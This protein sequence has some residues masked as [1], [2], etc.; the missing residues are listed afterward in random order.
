MMTYA[1]ATLL[2]V[3]NLAAWTAT[4]F[5]LPGNWFI[6]LMAAGYAYLMRDAVPQ[7]T[8]HVVIATLALAVI[9]E[10][11][12]LLAGVLGVKKLG[13]SRRGMIY[14]VIGTIAGSIVGA[15]VGVPIPVVGPIVGALGCG[16][17]GAF[18]GAYLGEVTAGRH[19]DDRMAIGKAALI[20][21]LL[22]TGGKLGVGLL[23]VILV[24]IDSFF[25]RAV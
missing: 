25:D 6:V 1:A 4:L 2:F 18:A 7:L 17:A 20:G 15:M 12:E 8:W 14:S 21:R 19:H 24:A 23:M 16:A 9:G 11:L 3:A 13:G 5:G 22:G 10:G